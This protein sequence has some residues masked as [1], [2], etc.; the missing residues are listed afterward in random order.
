MKYTN[1]VL[2]GFR[3][4]PS[5]CR[6]GRDYYLVNST[7]EYFPG[8]PLYHSTDLVNWEQIGHVLTEKSQLVPPKGAPNCA[9]I[10]A[11]TI[12]Y[13][14]GRFYCIVTNV[15][16]IGNFYVYTDDI[17]G[18]W[19][20]PVVLPFGGI[21]PSLFFDDDGRAYY[22]GIDNQIFVCEINIETGEPVGEKH[23]VWNGTGA[24]NPE[25]PHIYKING[26]YYL[27][28][29]EGGTEL[30]HMV[31]IARS[32][33]IFGE[34]ESCPHNPILTNR[35]TGL[36]IKAVGHA[37]IVEDMNGSWWAV[38]L[39]NRPTGYPFRHIMGR[40]TSL[41]P[42]K[43][44]NGWPVMGADGH[45]L[46]EFEVEAF[47]GEKT[48]DTGKYIPGSDMV[49]TFKGSALHPSW[50]YIYN[51]VDGLVT[52]DNGLKLWGNEFSIC[53]D[54]SKAL[55]CRRQ[56]H[57]CFNADAEILYNPD[58]GSEVGIS[59]YMNNRHHYEAAITC[60]KGRKSVLLRRQIG[61]L[62]GEEICAEISGETV[63]LRL[64]GTR[65]FYSFSYS[66]DGGEFNYIGG[67]ETN[68]LSTEAGGCFTGN[69]IALYASGNGKKAAE[70]ALFK[71]FA[72][73]AV[74]GNE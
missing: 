13:N 59:I 64:S 55:I 38:C 16:G 69:M 53:D 62:K 17:Y 67:C 22:S 41:V 14:N 26:W 20:D 50:E 3:P 8:I 7:F 60:K 74:N 37:D 4:D 5:V 24:N 45:V 71:S 56:E 29:A 72:Y 34:Y 23:F 11:P 47:A 58:E 46:E 28:I 10:Y 54:E 18:K 27:L 15:G 32:R 44:E 21:D 63:V 39:M 73:K 33:E 51:P 68:Y 36:P 35:G 66:V 31:T 70:P 42:V 9:G 2:P 1:P 30:G 25:G 57:F 52:V 61:S 43:W 49:D 12:R 40:E 19:S 6:V 65:N 48:P